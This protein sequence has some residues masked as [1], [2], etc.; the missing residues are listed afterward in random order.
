MLNTLLLASFCLLPQ[1]PPEPGP[2][3]EVEQTEVDNI[4]PKEA[5]ALLK[6]GLG[7]KDYAAQAALLE[8]LGMIPDKGVVK[9]VAKALKSK[10]QTVQLAALTALRFNTDSTAL[11]ELT[12]QKKNKKIIDVEE[13]AEEYYYALG[14]HGDKKAIDILASG[15]YSGAKNSKIIRARLLSLGHIRHIDSCEALMGLLKSRGGKRGHSMGQ[16]NEFRTAMAVLTGEDKGKNTTDWIQWWNDVK[17]SLEI[18]EEEWPLEKRGAQRQWQTL[19]ATPQEKEEMRKKAQEKK[20][21]KE[22][23]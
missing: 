1:D 3:P 14:Q 21:E 17:K 18:S 7:G 13:L 10:D 4:S 19:W 22:E 11:K 2:E 15:L 12:K 23:G 5:I 6:E 8:N 9:E 16:M 20:K